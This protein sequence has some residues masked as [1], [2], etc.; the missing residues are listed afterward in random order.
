M[1]Y[2]AFIF[3]LF[4]IIACNDA[5]TP[6]ETKPVVNVFGKIKSVAQQTIGGN[7]QQ[8]LFIILY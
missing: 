4:F 5:I 6:T 3:F 7:T 2:V 1:R 8:Q